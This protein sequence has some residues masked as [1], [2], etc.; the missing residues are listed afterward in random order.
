MLLTHA[1]YYTHIC[2]VLAR[3]RFASQDRKKKN[4]KAKIV[5]RVIQE[6]RVLRLYISTVSML[7]V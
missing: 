5:T 2:A 4:N 1:L 3:L 7:T 6:A